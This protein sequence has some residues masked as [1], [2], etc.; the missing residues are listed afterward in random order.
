MHGG[1]ELGGGKAAWC[2]KN[3]PPRRPDLRL[4]LNSCEVAFQV[5]LDTRTERDPPQAP[6]PRSLRNPHR[7]CFIPFSINDLGKQV[8]SL[9]AV[10]NDLILYL[11]IYDMAS[12]AQSYD[13][14]RVAALGCLGHSHDA[15]V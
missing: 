8:R 12:A 3:G 2:P 10:A 14:L 4:P 1:V 11:G 13:S 5:T 9:Q 15:H 7:N 6:L